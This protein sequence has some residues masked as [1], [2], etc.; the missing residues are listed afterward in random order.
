MSLVTKRPAVH[1]RP[2][3]MKHERSRTTSSHT[4]HP[5]TDMLR[6][7][8]SVSSSWSAGH[9][10]QTHQKRLNLTTPYDSLCLCL[11]LF[12]SVYLPFAYRR[13]VCL[14]TSLLLV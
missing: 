3:R 6:S 11:C 1:G 12:L 13:K 9:T 5:S 2:V 14:I 7:T 8:A 10:V 4:T